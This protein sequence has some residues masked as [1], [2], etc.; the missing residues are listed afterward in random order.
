MLCSVFYIAVCKHS[1]VALFWLSLV[2]VF[3]SPRG[4]IALQRKSLQMRGGRVS[5]PC[6]FES[7]FA[8]SLQIQNSAPFLGKFWPCRWMQ[9]WSNRRHSIGG[10]L[11]SPAI[12]LYGPTYSLRSR[13]LYSTTSDPIGR[14]WS[15]IS[16]MCLRKAVA[17]RCFAMNFNI[18]DLATLSVHIRSLWMG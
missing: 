10:F 4:S 6:F 16:G 12:T 3:V 15:V 13:S 18:S 2:V 1:T 11:V 5:S 14:S 17:K 7:A 9:E 8:W